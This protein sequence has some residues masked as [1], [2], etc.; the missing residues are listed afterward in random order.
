MAG[1]A[2][3][4]GVVTG[5][6]AVTLGA[7]GE[8]M[9]AGDAVNTAARVQ[10]AA[11][12]G[13]V[14][15]DEETR[16]RTTASIAYRD[17]G[18]H[19]LKGKAA[20]VGLFEV[21]AVVAAVAGSQ[22]IDGLVAP[23]TGRARELI[24]V[25]ELFHLHRRR[26]ASPRP[27]GHR[28]GRG[29]QVP[30][31][32]GVRVLRRRAVRPGLVAPGPVPRLRRRHGVLGTDRGTAGPVRHRSRRCVRRGGHPTASRSGRW[33]ADPARRTWLAPRLA[34]LL[35]G[36]VSDT[37]SFAREDL[38][39]AWLGFLGDLSRSGGRR[40]R[41]YWWWRTCSTPTTGCWTS[42]TRRWRPPASRCSC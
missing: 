32:L 38:F 11:E 40:P 22:R 41:S 3:R 21:R 23:F 36:S 29:G 15:V 34:T 4:V 7:V 39:G 42:W 25:K 31:G 26:P 20:E 5:E 8:G 12:P 19:R 14:W 17:A 27:A 1:L 33:V 35:G 9:V 18:E 16:R 10:A 37:G 24:L 6:V 13:R 30:A 2:L 28:C